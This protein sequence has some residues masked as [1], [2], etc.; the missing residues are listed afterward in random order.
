MSDKALQR[1]PK[2]APEVPPSFRLFLLALLYDI[3]HRFSRQALQ[4]FFVLDSGDSPV[5]R[6][7]LIKQIKPIRCNQTWNVFIAFNLS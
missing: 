5:S 2:L 7:R 6:I 3:P 1:P 4:A